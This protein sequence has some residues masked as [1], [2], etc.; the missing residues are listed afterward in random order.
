[1]FMKIT[2]LVLLA[3]MGVMLAFTSAQAGFYAGFQVG[4]NFPMSSGAHVNIFNQTVDTGNLAFATGF[5]IGVQAGYDFLSDTAN[6]PP[7]AQYFTVAVDYQYNS[8][9][10]NRQNFSVRI[11]NLIAQ[12]DIP[13]ASGSQNAL[14]FLGIVKV[15]LMMSEQY[16]KGRLFPYIGVGPS[17]VWT[18]IE[19]S[20]S[21]NV[22]VVV[23]PGV[24]FMFLP[25]ISGDLAYRFRYCA[26]SFS[27]FDNN[28]KVSFNSLNSAIVF[29]VNYHF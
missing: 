27:G 20:S 10:I 5:M 24:R 19:D 25:K 9:N 21:T 16:P 3:V 6:F 22:G 8:Y 11:G 13:S 1:M 7:W 26:P 2:R 18:A 29:R 15:P 14:T 28:V 4:P 12:G 23:E 17:I